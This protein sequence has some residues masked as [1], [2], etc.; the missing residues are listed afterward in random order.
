MRHPWRKTDW[1]QEEVFGTKY[2]AREVK[3]S[4]EIIQWESRKKIFPSLFESLNVCEYWI[5]YARFHWCIA[6]YLVLFVY[7][8][9]TLFLSNRPRDYNDFFSRKHIILHTHQRRILCQIVRT[10]GAKKLTIRSIKT[11]GRRSRGSCDIATKNE[12]Q[13]KNI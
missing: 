2:C 13:A 6:V 11:W 4:G 7:N 8:S 3:F 10:A 5:F 1:L 12:E 9:P